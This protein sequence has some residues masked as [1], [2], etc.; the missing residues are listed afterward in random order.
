MW[1]DMISRG[2]TKIN[3]NS[4]IRDPYAEHLA[5]ALSSG[6]PLPDAIEEA[7]EVNAKECERFFHLL[8]SAGKA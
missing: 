2:V 1:Q 6:T 8:G 4:W 3:V 7:I 5:R